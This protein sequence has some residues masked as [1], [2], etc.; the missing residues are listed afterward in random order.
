MKNSLFNNQK[1]IKRNTDVETER[2]T[3]AHPS[4]FD[5][6]SATGRGY[7]PEGERQ[8]NK[9]PTQVSFISFI[10]ELGA[11]C[12]MGLK[13]HCTVIYIDDDKR[14]YLHPDRYLH[15]TSVSGSSSFYH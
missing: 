7:R 11:H 15:E 12:M 13:H 9:C 2:P 1:L 4:S 6:H 14:A 10:I 5:G 8:V 3:G